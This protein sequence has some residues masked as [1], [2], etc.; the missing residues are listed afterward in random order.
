MS[1]AGTILRVD[2]TEG[3]IEKQP[4]STYTRDYIGGGGIGTKIF[5]DEV[6]PE[7]RAYDPRNLLTFNAGTLTGTLMGNKIEIISKSPQLTNNPLTTAGMGGQFGSEMKFAGYDNI[8]VKGKA[9][10]PVYLFIHN[11]K[12]DIRDA[13]HLWGLD[14]YETQTSIKDELM[15]PDVQIACI[16]PAGENMVTCALILHSIDNT[17]SHG[18]LGA[19]MGSKNLKAVAVRGTKGLKIADP[20]AFIALWKEYW[21]WYTKG[22]GDAIARILSREGTS[23]HIYNYRT[24]D[25]V[26]WGYYEKNTIPPVTKKEEKISAFQKEYSVGPVGCAFCPIQCHQNYHVPGI[27]AS[28]AHCTAYIGFPLLAKSLDLKLWWLEMV[29]VHRYGME[30][31]ET[32]NTISWLMMMYEKGLITAADTDGVPMEW[33]SEI[34]V[35]TVIEKIAKKEGFGKLFTDGIVPAAKVLSNGEGLE[36]VRQ[37]SNRQAP[38]PTMGGGFSGNELLTGFVNK[39]KSQSYALWEQGF[40]DWWPNIPLYAEYL[41]I[42]TEEAKKMAEG[43]MFEYVKGITGDGNLW[44]EG[45]YDPRQALIGVVKEDLVSACDIAGHCDWMSDRLRQ[46]GLRTNIDDL[47]KWIRA[48]T[49][50]DCTSEMLVDAAGRKRLL[51][52]S[53][54][55]LCERLIGEKPYVSQYW[56]NRGLAP[57]TGGYYKGDVVNLEKMFPVALEYYK[58]RGYDS[59]G[60]P[61]REE[62]ERRGLKDVADRLEATGPIPSHDT[63]SQT[64]KVKVPKEK[65]S[66]VV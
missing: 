47:A 21:E 9:D 7:T 61:T 15:D 60:V 35:K 23:R 52:A 22:P 34:A 11:D 27:G 32:V 58:L 40:G 33:G 17:A 4:T 10:R 28:G 18:G 38:F 66:T 29:L 13:R 59:N 31:A 62:L 36:Y 45:V 50:M 53:Y 39:Y 19:V 8:I 55:V 41:G 63:D 57:V 3:K 51:E 42:S 25:M 2:L 26:A 20:E 54:N 16:G 56:M 30:S 44:E 46:Q 49:G 1:R 43:W 12:V 65:I 37:E 64:K 6:P 24:R 14:T 5:W 48:A